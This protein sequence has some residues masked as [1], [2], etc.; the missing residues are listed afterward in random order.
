MFM[1][2]GEIEAAA[3]ATHSCP[4]VRKAVQL[5]LKLMRAVN[6]QSDGWGY[7]PAPSKST[8]KLH[9]LLKTTG[10]LDYGTHGKISDADLKKAIA[11]I[12]AMVK[13]QKEV[14]AKHGNKFDFDVD[15]ALGNAPEDDKPETL[16]DDKPEATKA[17]A[18]M[19]WDILPKDPDHEDRRRLD[20]GYG[21]KTKLGLRRT[22]E[23]VI[24]PREK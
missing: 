5:L 6:D 1:N 2:Q 17:I 12:R 23:S 22:I 10:N 11:P 8:E 19:L 9:E 14:Q 4:N 20:G 18:D 3:S 13:H 15:A 21:T 7:W 16:N 24:L